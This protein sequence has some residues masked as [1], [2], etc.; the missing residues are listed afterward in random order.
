MAD[1]L[2]GNVKDKVE[3]VKAHAPDVLKTGVDTIREA[4]QVLDRTKDELKKTLKQ[5][6]EKIGHQLANL[7][8]PTRK[9]QAEAKKEEVKEKKRARRASSARAKAP[10]ESAGTEVNAAA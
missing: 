4:R 1:T 3:L 6:A 8:T 10:A 7:A 5:G 2:I 9:E